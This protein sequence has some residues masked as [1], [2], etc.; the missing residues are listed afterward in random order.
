M[1]NRGFVFGLL[2]ALVFGLVLAGCNIEPEPEEKFEKEISATPLIFNTWANGQLTAGKEQWFKFTATAEAQ[3]IHIDRG[4]LTDLYVQLHDSAGEA[5][6]NRI[7][8]NSE[9]DE[10]FNLSLIS[11]RAYY[12]K[13]SPYS[14][15]SGTYK[16]AFNTTIA[17]PDTWALMNSAPVL[18]LDNW[19]SGQLNAGEMDWYKFTAT[20]GTQWFHIDRST[21]TD[22]N[23]QLRDSEGNAVGS[24]KNI[25]GESDESF[26]WMVISGNVYYLRVRPHLSSGSGTYRI[27][28]N[29]SDTP[30]T[31]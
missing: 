4:T 17:S 7:H 26:S 27:A 22:L 29:T 9:D 2:A 25:D 23:V 8:I 24:E 15:G 12:L 30:P 16:V 31:P 19:V 13:V 14:S 5:V 21:L 10:T 3:Y 18:I 6:G 28:F 20:T 1:K 11:G